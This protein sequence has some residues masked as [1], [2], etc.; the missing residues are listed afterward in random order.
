MASNM[1]RGLW[2][3]GP[4]DQT[5]PKASSSHSN[6]A[7]RNPF[8]TMQPPTMTKQSSR[9]SLNS[10][11]VGTNL[12]GDVTP[13]MRTPGGIT[14]HSSI[15]TT[16]ISLS[17][18][19]FTMK[20]PP[21]KQKNDATLPSANTPVPMTDAAP[22]VPAASA[23][24]SNGAISSSSTTASGPT[25]TRNTNAPRGHLTVKIVAGRNLAVS[26]AAARPYAVIQFDKNEF[27]GREPIDEFGE[28]A[29]GIAQP[30]SEAGEAGRSRAKTVTP[31][32]AIAR[33]G[34]N[35]NPVWKHEVTFDVTQDSQPIYISVYD[36]HSEDEGFLGMREIKPRLVH[37]MMSDQ[38]YPLSSRDDEEGVENH[39]GEIRVQ[40]S[41]ERMPQKKLLPHDFEY[42]KLI[43]RGTF[44]RVFQVRKKDTKR[45][46][47]MKVLSKREIALKKEVTHTMGE[48]KILEKSLDCPFLVGLKFSF[49]SATEL[50]FVTDYKSG[51]ELFWHLQREGRFTEERARF[52]IAELVLALEHLH[53]YD[54]VYRDLK[55]E[56]I[57]LDATGHVAL[58]DFGLS[59]PD[60]GA[61]QLTN[62]FC[63]TTEYLAPEVLLD[64]SGY[65]KLV[66][67]WSLGVLLFEMCCGWSPFYAEDTQQMYRNICF[68]KI[69]FPRGAIG[70]DGK[71]FVKGLL[72]RNPRHRLGA[73]RDAQDLKEHPFFKDIDFDALAKKQLTP[74]FKPLVESDESVAN[75]DPEFTETDLKDVAVIPG[76][77]G[78]NVDAADAL[79]NGDVLGEKDGK[80]MAINNKARGGG[81]E[82]DQLLTRSVQDK[83]RG[84]SYSGTYEGSVAGSFGGRSR[85]GGFGLA[86]ASLG[87]SRMGVKDDDDQMDGEATFNQLDQDEVMYNR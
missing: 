29:K 61:G 9:S 50:Y 40:I 18:P 6:G 39:R 5:T 24:T 32:D 55:P 70:D 13:G 84:F 19:D 85:S 64:E 62:T 2:P 81:D 28:E 8:D 15:P 73:Q 52:Y 56:N 63:G 65:S 22:A 25:R 46:Y 53:K 79:S 41:Y 49:Q 14:S 78:S 38:W 75:F 47:A 74:P 45:I 36:R 80:G 44:G 21:P 58:C 71:Q 87:M 26:S 54:I 23:S 12:P 51:G 35:H 10:S 59:K 3:A 27:I 30:R 83:F 16:S 67:F 76:F 43:G 42:L 57:L 77:E 37:K 33:T 82:D 17:D 60:L 20:L 68:G 66:D 34:Q 69:K 31:A 72:N 11:I 86:G 7:E 48:R 4:A 1:L